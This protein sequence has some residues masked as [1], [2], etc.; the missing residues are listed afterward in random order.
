MANRL[1]TVGV[2]LALLGSAIPARAESIHITS[3][4]FVWMPSE[5]TPITLT[6]EGFTFDGIGHT[7]GVFMPQ[8]LCSVPECKVGTIVD[9]RAHWS[10]ADLPGTVTYKG[11]TYDQLGGLASSASLLAE[12][13]GTVTIPTGFTGG[14]VTAP[15]TF[16]GLFSLD[17]VGQINLFGG[18][19]AALDFVPYPGFPPGQGPDTTGAFLLTAARYQM[20]ESAPVP[21]PASMVLIG[22][23]L[24]GL[25]ALRR[26]RNREVIE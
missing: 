3:G 16:M 12:W 20:S 17:G 11:I 2:A 1:M 22:T 6:G 9:L 10:G 23:G 21:E 4:G 26:R 14:T 25:A 5:P 7:T 24:A 8:L 13:N 19:T 18:G 15:V